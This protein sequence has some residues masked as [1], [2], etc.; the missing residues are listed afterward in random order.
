LLPLINLCASL[1]LIACARSVSTVFASLQAE[2][3]KQGESRMYYL[4]QAIGN[5]DG[6]PFILFSLST[7]RLSLR[8]E[9]TAIRWFASNPDRGF[10]DWTSWSCSPSD[11]AAASLL[12]VLLLRFGLLSIMAS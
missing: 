7:L 10:P 1:D 5:K 3:V 8:L 2:A 4:K 11:R 12:L 6:A 9:H